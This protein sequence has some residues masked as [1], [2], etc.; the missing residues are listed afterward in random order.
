M[1]KNE[2]WKQNCV[3]L[4]IYFTKKKTVKLNKTHN[5]GYKQ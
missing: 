4:D 2:K 1:H 5:Q 3:N